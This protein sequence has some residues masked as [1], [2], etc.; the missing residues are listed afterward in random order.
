MN[1]SSIPY[2]VQLND[3]KERDLKLKALAERG[4][5]EAKARADKVLEL[6]AG[7]MDVPVRMLRGPFKLPEVEVQI[8]GIEIVG[9]AADDGEH[10]WFNPEPEPKKS[11]T[12][13]LK[14]YKKPKGKLYTEPLPLVATKEWD[15]SLKYSPM[16]EQV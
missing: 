8:N 16:I 14:D 6:L 2:S 11:L 5:M 4:D 7:A 13:Y 1:L 12:N 9:F 3:L 15:L 10:R